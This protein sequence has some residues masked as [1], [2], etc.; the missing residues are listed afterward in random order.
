MNITYDQACVVDSFMAD[1]MY[2]HSISNN[3][4]YMGCD[5]G[6]RVRALQEGIRRA[7][8]DVTVHTGGTHPVLVHPDG[9]TCIWV[10]GNLGE[11]GSWFVPY[12][13][14]GEGVPCDHEHPMLPNDLDELA[15]ALQLRG[16][17]L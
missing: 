10:S 17:E 14:G 8:E 12:D 2:G 9:H 3:I 15:I 16:I 4:G 11:N 13:V 6:C 1:H 7:L 5:A